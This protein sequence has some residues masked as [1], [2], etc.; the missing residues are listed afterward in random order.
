MLGAIKEWFSDFKNRHT[1]FFSLFIFAKDDKI[2][3]FIAILSAFAFVIVILFGNIVETKLHNTTI[4]LD[5]DV[6]FTK[7][8]TTSISEV[9]GHVVN[10]FRSSD[11]KKVFM[12][13]KFDDMSK[14]STDANLYRMFMTTRNTLNRHI[15]I[16]E[17]KVGSIFY[18]F[19]STGYVGIYLVDNI[20]F[21]KRLYDI[22]L[23]HNRNLSEIKKLSDYELADFTEHES[24]LRYD[25]SRIYFN[26]TGKKGTVAKFLDEGNNNIFDIYEET[27]TQPRERLIRAKL[28]RQL[29]QMQTDLSVIKEYKERVERLGVVV[30]NEPKAI[31]GD[32]V[33]A[34]YKGQLLSLD[35][36][37]RYVDQQGNVIGLNDIT[38]AIDTKYTISGG[39]NF[40]W[41]NGNIKDGYLNKLV[42]KGMSYGAFFKK[43]FASRASDFESSSKRVWKYK[44]GGVVDLTQSSGLTTVDKEI[45][46]S[47]TR[48][49]QAWLNYYSHKEGYQ[50]DGLMELLYLESDARE[51]DRNY[52]YND[53][54]GLLLTY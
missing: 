51:A 17:N 13:L 16:E 9:N 32:S 53:K 5:Q 24:F 52:T 30:D 12:L 28:D 21:D 1:K 7:D 2:K 19:G 15:A 31:R 38:W 54:D 18:V 43:K 40:D 27:V 10:V 35:E 33:K 42:P 8:F 36:D 48:L 29:A 3:K 25:Q 23:R 50:R 6:I 37:E 14:L 44:D 4:S 47:I 46:D 20:G 11:F 39:F 41:Q 45:V 49:E 34:Y 22:I 26:P